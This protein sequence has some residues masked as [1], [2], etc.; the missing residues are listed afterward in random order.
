MLIWISAYC[1]NTKTE[2]SFCCLILDIIKVYWDYNIIE[3]IPLLTSD[4]LSVF[5]KPNTNPDKSTI[6]G[7][8]I[9]ESNVDIA[10]TSDA[11]TAFL[12]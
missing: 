3:S 8:V 4:I 2:L 9:P 11:L 7:S 12:L 1:G 5:Y 10:K 6:M